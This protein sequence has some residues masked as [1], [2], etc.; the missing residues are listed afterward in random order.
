MPE[1]NERSEADLRRGNVILVKGGRA[2]VLQPGEAL[3]LIDRL[4]AWADDEKRRPLL[5]EL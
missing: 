1:Q 4:I 3:E 2:L 5:I